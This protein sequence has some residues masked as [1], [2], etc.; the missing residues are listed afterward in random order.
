LQN[1]TINVSSTIIYE[2]VVQPTATAV[3]APT[4]TAATVIEAIPTPSDPID[5]D[6]VF[7]DFI[8]TWGIT[9]GLILSLGMI[10]FSGEDKGTKWTGA[11]IL[12]VVIMFGIRF[13]NQG[14]QPRFKLY[15]QSPSEIAPPIV[16]EPPSSSEIVI[17]P[18][19]ERQVEE[20]VV[21]N[22]SLP[23]LPTIGASGEITP[24]SPRTPP[25]GD[26]AINSRWPD[27]IQQW[28]TGITQYA[29]AN[30][31]NPD[32]I[33]AMMWQE[34]LGNPDTLSSSCAVGLIQV[35][36]SDGKGFIL[37]NSAGQ[38]YFKCDLVNGTLE[39]Y[40]SYYSNVFRNRPTIAQIQ[41]DPYFGLEWGVSYYGGLLRGHNS[42]DWEALYYYGGPRYGDV[43]RGAVFNHYDCVVNNQVGSC[44]SDLASRLNK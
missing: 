44:R 1:I 38:Q 7:D 20:V 39:A 37:T 21:T 30:G 8:K 24:A 28:C 3:I 35:M 4:P 19:M 11:L 32:R 25:T 16:T 15:Q 22:V 13:Y 9:I 12:I 40:Q 43:Y 5:R 14:I 33:A 41:S 23:G 17:P 18:A 10:A 6:Q 29:T 34:T 42:S 26:C 36:P 31:A 27:S 2:D